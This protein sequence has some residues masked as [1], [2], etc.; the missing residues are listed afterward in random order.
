MQFTYQDVHWKFEIWISKRNGRSVKINPFLGSNFKWC[1]R[2]W[3]NCLNTN[4]NE[5]SFYIF[6]KTN[7][8]YLQYYVYLRYSCKSWRLKLGD[9]SG[10]KINLNR[11]AFSF[12]KVP[13]QVFVL[14][15]IMFHSLPI[16]L[17]TWLDLEEAPF[18]SRYN[19]SR[20][21]QWQSG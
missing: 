2:V 18:T 11:K 9:S 12:N 1:I 20:V 7:V 4:V 21:I 17:T 3:C 10:I 16:L 14:K 6:H 19:E 5:V 8:I 15:N 13:N